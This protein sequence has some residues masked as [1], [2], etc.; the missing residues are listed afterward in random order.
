M[1]DHG[2][3]DVGNV[4]LVKADQTV[5]VGDALAQRVQRIDRAL[6]LCQLAVHLPHELMKMQAG[7]APDR[8]RAKKAVHQEAFAPPDPS[9]K[10]NASGNTG[11]VDELLECIGPLVLVMLPL[12][13]TALERCNAAQL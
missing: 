8:H 9:V 4:E 10:V 3:G 7:L 6:Q 12:Q 13:R 1:Q 5:F 2:V 11:A